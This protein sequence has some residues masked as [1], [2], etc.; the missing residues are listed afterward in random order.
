MCPKTIIFII[1]FGEKVY[2]HT[3]DGSECFLKLS[4]HLYKAR[5]SLLICLD[6][7]GFVLC[8]CWCFSVGVYFS[9]KSAVLETQ[10]NLEKP[11][12]W[13]ASVPR[14]PV[15]VSFSVL[16][17]VFMYSLKTHFQFQGCFCR[18]I[19]QEEQEKLLL[20]HIPRCANL[21]LVKDVEVLLLFFNA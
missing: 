21:T 19:W 10:R 5:L 1:I 16:L 13:L 15:C 3:G 2:T 8:I 17:R 14:S 4:S 20:F 11:L 12:S 18:H 7:T 9:S 6:G